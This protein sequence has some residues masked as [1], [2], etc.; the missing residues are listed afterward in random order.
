NAASKEILIALLTGLQGFY[1]TDRKRNNPRWQGDLYLSFK[2]QLKYFPETNSK[3]DEVGYL[4]DTFPIVNATGTGTNGISAQVLADEIVAC[5]NAAKGR[6]CTYD[7]K[8]KLTWFGGPFR[9]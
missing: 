6:Y 3:G 4:V 2:M 7:P 5:R 9:S 1:V 8:Q